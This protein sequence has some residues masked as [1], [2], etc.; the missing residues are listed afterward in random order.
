M[1]MKGKVK[2]FNS[3]KGYGFIVTEDNKEFFAH[4]KSIVSKT[5]NE[6]KVLEQNEKVEFD[7]LE[8][9]KGVQAINIIKL[10]V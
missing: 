8:T 5:P 10:N 6:L 7:L 1:P 2:W 9:Q 4:W 3:N